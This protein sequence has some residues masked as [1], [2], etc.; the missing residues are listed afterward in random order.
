M[1]VAAAIS[2]DRTLSVIE[3]EE[4]PLSADEVRVDVAFCGLCGSDLLIFFGAPEPLAGHV[5][6][7]EF[8]GVVRET[9]SGVSGWSAGDRVV[10]RPIKSC[11]S[12]RECRGDDNAVCIAGIMGGPGLGCPGGL[13]DSVVV[14]AYM[15]HRVPDHLSL[16]HAALAEPLAVAVRGVRHARVSGGDSVVITGAGPIGALTLEVL[17]AYGHERILVV[18]P[19]PERRAMAA[20]RGVLTA[21]PADVAA[22]V[23]EHFPEG[24]AA[25][26][27]CTGR[28]DCLQ[29]NVDV[30]GYGTRIVILGIASAPAEVQLMA[31]ALKEVVIIGS[32]GYSRNDFTE[33]LELL[34]LGKVKA[35]ALVTSVVEL[36]KA[37][38]KLRELHS[39]STA[40]IKVLVRH[41]TH[42]G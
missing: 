9:G 30:A 26:L 1:N 41:M 6:G 25:I 35:E 12:C 27:D 2:S 13:G 29:H 20:R 15:L 28:A 19:N 5:M 33:A 18:E 14:P 36:G 4:Q 40:D 24:V 8:S 22:M 21:E 10:V 3:V 11:G 39:G 32:T 17:K 7:H 31:V 23:A 42:S 34:A 16:E 37:D 38:A